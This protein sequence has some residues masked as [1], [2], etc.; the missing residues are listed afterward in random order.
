MQTIAATYPAITKLTS[1]GVSVRGRQLWVLE[2][3]DNP[4]SNESGEPEFKYI[5]NMH[6]DEVVGRYGFV[7]YHSQLLQ[8]KTPSNSL[9]IL[10]R[11]TE[12]MIQSHNSS[13]PPPFILCLP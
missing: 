2:I 7:S 3:S 1:V 10:L 4:G 12:S 11:I 5:A 13:I 8:E 9:T 6:G